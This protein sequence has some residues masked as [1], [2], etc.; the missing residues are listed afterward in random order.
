MYFRMGWPGIRDSEITNTKMKQ[1]WE[2][3]IFT[4]VPNPEEQGGINMLGELMGTKAVQ[5]ARKASSPSSRWKL[6][7]IEAII[8]PMTSGGDHI[9]LHPWPLL[10]SH[11]SLRLLFYQVIIL[12]HSNPSLFLIIS[13]KIY[14]KI[15]FPS[16]FYCHPPTRQPFKVSVS[17]LLINKENPFKSPAYTSLRTPT[18]TDLSKY[19]KHENQK[20]K[21][22]IFSDHQIARWNGCPYCRFFSASSDFNL[23]F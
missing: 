17:S 16:R 23:E 8:T 20:E 13:S 7:G 11:L 19:W 10:S 4:S 15:S 18:H 21:I 2:S 22:S 3:K 9:F 1:A 14:N 5:T 6:W 12:T